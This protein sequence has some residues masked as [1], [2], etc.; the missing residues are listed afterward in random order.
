[1]LSIMGRQTKR[2]N[3]VGTKLGSGTTEVSFGWF[4]KDGSGRARFAWGKKNK[5]TTDNAQQVLL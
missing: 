5:K 2:I 1:M 3:K 4:A